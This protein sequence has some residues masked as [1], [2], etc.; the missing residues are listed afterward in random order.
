[1]EEIT[2]ERVAPLLPKHPENA[3]K[4]DVGTLLCITGS[5]RMT[6]AAILCA[7]GALLS[8]TGLLYQSSPAYAQ[9]ILQT[10]LYE[11]VFLSNEQSAIKEYLKK[12]KA[13]VFGCGLE[14]SSHNTRLLEY[15]L[16]E[17]KTPVLIDASGIAMLEDAGG[18][19]SLNE[20]V[21]LTP[22][23]GEMARLTHKS[24]TD[25]ERTVREFCESCR[26][27]LVL[28]GK[29]TIVGKGESLYVNT[30]GS[31]A[32]AK[33]GYGDLLSGMMGALLSQGM[34]NVSAAVS[35]VYLHGLAGD[36]T[37]EK[38]TSF[39]AIPTLCAENIPEAFKRTY[40]Q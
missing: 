4:Y 6:G 23:E 33:G 22:H 35:A 13:V 5:D 15:I 14:I 32:M 24:I 17:C 10:A 11:P 21:I 27:T 38:Y 7:K 36:I 25:R 8:G 2:R 1:M 39:G 31:S 34:D 16:N 30:T 29:N 20:N 19:Q 12:A 40:K 18:I 37:A 9:S 28:K 3:H 26:A